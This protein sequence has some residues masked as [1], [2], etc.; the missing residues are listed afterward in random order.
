[1]IRLLVIRLA[2]GTGCGGG[3]RGGQPT[4]DSGEYR[5]L[6]G[7]RKFIER[8]QI[9][10]DAVKRVRVR[11]TWVHDHS[12]LIRA[13]LYAWCQWADAIT[14]ISPF[15]HMFSPAK[16][17]AVNRTCAQFPISSPGGRPTTLEPQSI[18]FNRCEIRGPV[19]SPKAERSGA[20]PETNQH[21]L[22]HRIRSSHREYSM[23]PT[24]LAQR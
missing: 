20:E 21:R 11:W 7:D 9:L 22:C 15:D 5:Y 19:R 17:V 14:S 13:A 12:F 6:I 3:E 18:T 1:M 24:L 8:S 10:V 2:V 16:F 4:V 23:L